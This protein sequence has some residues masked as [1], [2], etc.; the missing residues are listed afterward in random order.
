MWRPRP[1]LESYMTRLAK[2]VDVARAV[3]DAGDEGAGPRLDDAA[4]SALAVLPHG[5][6]LSSSLTNALRKKGILGQAIWGGGPC[7]TLSL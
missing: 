6:V 2:R 7:I 4:V 5:R 3:A 1:L